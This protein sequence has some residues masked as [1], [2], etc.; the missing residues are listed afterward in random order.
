[1][2]HYKYFLAI[3]VLVL[4]PC[5]FVFPQADSNELSLKQSGDI[6]QKFTSLELIL[7]NSYSEHTDIMSESDTAFHLDKYAQSN[8]SKVLD[9]MGTRMG[10]QFSEYLIPCIYKY[11]TDSDK[12][13]IIDLLPMY[14]DLVML[15][16]ENDWHKSAES[17]LIGELRNNPWGLPHEWSRAVAEIGKTEYLPLLRKQLQISAYPYFVYH[18][19]ISVYPSADL[20]NDLLFV[21]EHGI[22]DY[23]N[24]INIAMLLS[25]MGEEAGLEFVF[26]VIAGEVEN[27]DHYLPEEVYMQFIAQ[28]FADAPKDIHKFI[29]WYKNNKANIHYDKEQKKYIV[30]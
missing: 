7:L 14:P 15:V 5:M 30:K 24:K 25:S 26:S 29:T 3:T 20:R 16:I 8:F 4:L 1:M 27:A 9:I 11:A 28:A 6:F 22:N 10:S 2:K 21:W 13:R 17:T 23:Y 19:I 12:T 18:Y